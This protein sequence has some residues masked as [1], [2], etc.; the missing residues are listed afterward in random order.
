MC[1]GF[2]DLEPLQLSG[3]ERLGWDWR[4]SEGRQL[5]QTFDCEELRNE[6]SI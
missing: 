6:G 3:R 1:T 5:F 4:R 2:N